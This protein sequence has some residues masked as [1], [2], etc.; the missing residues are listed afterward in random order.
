MKCDFSPYTVIM[1]CQNEIKTKC[2]IFS[3]KLSWIFNYSY[4]RKNIDRGTPINID[5]LNK[6]SKKS[7]GFEVWIVGVMID[8]M[9]YN[10]SEVFENVWLKKGICIGWRNY[11]VEKTL[12]LSINGKIPKGKKIKIF[13]EKN[14]W[15][16]KLKLT[17]KLKKIT[18][19]PYADVN[20]ELL[21][22]KL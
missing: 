2:G 4:N 6:K 19:N 21:I 20:D 13:F 22:V 15:R 5:V 18:V 16:G 10:A 17:Y 1:D 8:D 11:D 9:W 12:P 14:K 3:K 7:L